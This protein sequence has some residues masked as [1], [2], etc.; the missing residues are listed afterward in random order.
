MIILA[1]TPKE[2]CVPV[3][4][5]QSTANLSFKEA[6]ASYCLALK[7]ILYYRFLLRLNYWQI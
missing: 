4:T 3:I 5:T 7:Y 6:V 2:T 1:V